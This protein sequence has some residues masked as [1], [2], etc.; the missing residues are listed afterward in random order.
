[1]D[2][3]RARRARF[4]LPRRRVVPRRRVRRRRRRFRWWDLRRRFCR[5]W[6]CRLGLPR[7]AF[8]G[9]CVL[10]TPPDRR[11]R[12]RFL[13]PF[14]TVW[15]ETTVLGSP[16]AVWSLPG[17]STRKNRIV[18]AAAS[19][20]VHYVSISAL[21]KFASAAALL[22]LSVLP[23]FPCPLSWILIILGL[24]LHS[25]S[26][27]LGIPTFLF[28]SSVCVA[29]AHPCVSITKLYTSGGGYVDN[30]QQLHIICIYVETVEE[31]MLKGFVFGL[32]RA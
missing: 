28:L 5:R 10:Y 24:L 13:F 19:T 25:Y 18:P 7:G 30:R 2:D 31:G 3:G 27:A 9:L 23:S 6:S 17:I 8:V 16:L 15:G 14:S 21:P 20:A 32:V 11:F 12:I 29:F 4:R 1:M 22:F 26:Y